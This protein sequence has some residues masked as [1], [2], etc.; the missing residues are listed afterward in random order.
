LNVQIKIV[1]R[2]ELSITINRRRENAARNSVLGDKIKSRRAAV[3]I[4][5]RTVVRI[6]RRV[7]TQI[8][9]ERRKLICRRQNE[10]EI[11]QRAARRARHKLVKH[12][13][14]LRSDH[15]AGLS[16]L[17]VLPGVL[18]S[19]RGA[20]GIRTVSGISFDAAIDPQVESRRNFG[21]V[22]GL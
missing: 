17:D 5:R 7:R 8:R 14:R 19:D 12:R 21:G 22:A 16:Q 1:G 6:T 11:G 4:P 9:R 13:L 3:K 18:L 10:G 15:C 20:A 2:I